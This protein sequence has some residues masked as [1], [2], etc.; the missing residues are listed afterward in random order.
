MYFKFEK[1]IVLII[2]EGSISKSNAEFRKFMGYA[3]RSLAELITCINKAKLRAYISEKK[4]NKI[5]A[6]SFELM[7]KMIAF[8]RNIK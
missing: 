7:N 6:E 3:I 2:S 5:Y 1:I 8:R 4:F